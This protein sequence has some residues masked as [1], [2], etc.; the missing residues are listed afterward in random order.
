VVPYSGPQ[1]ASKEPRLD[2]CPYHFLSKAKEARMNTKEAFAQTINKVLS[3]MDK[4][5]E[6]IL[7]RAPKGFW[8]E[9]I[10]KF[11][12]LG[13]KKDRG[14]KWDVKQASQYWKRHKADIISIMEDMTDKKE[15]DEQQDKPLDIS[16]N[17]IPSGPNKEEPV[18]L[19]T[20]YAPE[21][22]TNNIPIS[23]KT[24][25]RSRQAVPKLAPNPES[26]NALSDHA[27]EIIEML[28]WWRGK[29][30]Q[31]IHLGEARPILDGGEGQK[32]TGV[33]V[34][35]K[36]LKMATEKAQKERAQTGGSVSKLVE[37]LLWK[38]LGEPEEFIVR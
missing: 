29:K 14:G 27:D 24:A 18:D 8:D 3:D 17:D 5:L 11:T 2:Q 35:L 37:L 28:N 32:N 1:V 15:S 34:D 30:D 13:I 10:E 33:K 38:Y 31:Q 25:D 26:I 6:D 16:T 19:S 12:I 4:Q 23:P 20:D 9:V 7:D 36:I 22:N 21:S